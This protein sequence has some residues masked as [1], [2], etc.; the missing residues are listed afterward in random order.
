MF[1][2]HRNNVLLSEILSLTLKRVLRISVDTLAQMIFLVEQ[3][4]ATAILRGQS[5]LKF[6]EVLRSLPKNVEK[7]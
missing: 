7:G 6:L 5:L 3:V 1:P 4:C 2:F